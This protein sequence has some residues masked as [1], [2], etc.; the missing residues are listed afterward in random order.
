MY[1]TDPDAEAGHRR[2]HGPRGAAPPGRHPRR[3]RGDHQGAAHR[4]PADPA[5]AGGRPGPRGRAGRHPVRDARRRGARPAEDGLPRPAQPRR[6]HRHR[7]DDPSARGDPSFDID[8]DPA[9]RRADV[10]P[11]VRGATRS[12][13]S[14]WSRRRCGSCSAVAGADQLRGRRPPCSRCTGPGRWRRTCTT[15]TPTARTA[16]S[17]S[18]TSTPTPRRC[19]ATRTA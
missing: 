2:R 19:S 17:R 4:L 6:H 8:D 7:G 9:R 5:Q 16:A 10:R 3:R 18:S 11:A 14:S 13:C 15:T 12:A 1:D